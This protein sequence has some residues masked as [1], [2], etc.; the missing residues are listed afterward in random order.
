MQH[1]APVGIRHQQPGTVSDIVRN[2]HDRG[3]E[4][5]FKRLDL[6]GLNH[7]CTSN[8]PQKRET[9]AP[10]RKL[11]RE[12]VAPAK[13]REGSEVDSNSK[14]AFSILR[15][16]LGFAALRLFL[17]TILHH[18]EFLQVDLDELGGVASFRAPERAK[19]HGW[20]VWVLVLYRTCVGHKQK[21]LEREAALR[22]YFLGCG[23]RI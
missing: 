2:L 16:Q 3:K 11:P 8:A 13:N 18:L 21:G 12:P 5:P 1:G 14:F 20:G 4:A 22:P 9:A 15:E 17:C 10:G 19:K 23:G 7:H 6:I